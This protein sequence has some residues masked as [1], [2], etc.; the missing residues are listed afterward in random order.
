MRKLS[1][2]A[3]LGSAALSMAAPS[4]AANIELALAI[5]DSGSMSLAQFNLQKQGYINALSDISVLA[6]D[7][8]VAIGIYKFSSS[9]VTVFSMQEITSANFASL[10]TALTN[11]SYVG[12]STNIAGALD[13][14]TADIFGNSVTSQRQVIDVSTDG[15][16]NIGNLSTSRANALAAGIDQINCL[17]IGAGAQCGPV[18]GGVGS[19]SVVANDFGDFESTLRAKIIRETQGAVP[20]PSTWAMMIGGFGLVGAAMRRRRRYNLK[21]S[22]A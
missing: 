10:I 11:M 3:L 19:F 7:G 1:L 16:N 20:E 15:G 14:A 22:F 21:V 5:D 18:Q 2:S 17:G 9:V 6:R 13:V 12:G 4:Q 8:S